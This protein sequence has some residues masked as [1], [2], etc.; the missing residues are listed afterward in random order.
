M[1]DTIKDLKDSEVVAPTTSPFN[2]TFWSVRKT[3][4]YQNINQD[5]TAVAG[6]VPDVASLFEQINISLR[7]V[8]I[9]LANAHKACHKQFA[10]SYRGRHIPLQFYLKDVLALLPLPY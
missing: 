1:S 9:D 5:V 7:H 3:G 8:A 2:S 6:A 10:F 4:D